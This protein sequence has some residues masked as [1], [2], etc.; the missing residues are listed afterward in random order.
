M[1]L[2]K[3][4]IVAPN[5]G[6]CNRLRTMVSAVYLA[7]KLEMNIEH[8]WLGT[9]YHC[10]NNNIQNIHNKSFEYYFEENIKRCDYKN[11]INNVNNVYSEWLPGWCWYQFQSYGQK[12]LKTSVLLNLDLVNDKMDN[13]QNFLIESSHINNLKM[14][15][16]DKN[17]I[18]KTYF[19]PKNKFLNEINMMDEN[20]I[21][22][23][24]RKG[25]FNIY[26]PETQ[27]DDKLIIKW[28]ENI[29]SK[30]YFCSDDKIFEREI[31]KNLKNVLIPKFNNID[32]VNDI[33]FLEFLSLSKCTKIY[34]TWKSSFSEEAALFGGIEYIPLKKDLICTTND[35]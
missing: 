13:S 18:Y 23:H 8:L 32:D 28:I 26:F 4:L 5:A 16:N 29:N 6:F 24:I 20:I 25:D 7:E 22:I 19:I 11:M 31:R 1:N 10:A 17:R 9:S 33:D 35:L 34:G 3:T 30:I 15:K 21:G 27:I 12:L 14:T 2:K